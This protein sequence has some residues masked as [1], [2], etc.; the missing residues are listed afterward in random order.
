MASLEQSAFEPSSQLKSEAKQTDT[1]TELECEFSGCSWKSPK[2]EL[3]TVV[4]LMKMHFAAKHAKPDKVAKVTSVKAEKAKRPEIAIEMTD[5]DWAYF[6]S[7]WSAYKKATGLEGEDIMLQ[8]MECC[9]EQLRKD[10]YRNFPSTTS[11]SSESILLAQLKQIA[12][13]VK[14]RAVNRFKL[15]TLHQDKG[16][17]IRRF[18][19]RCRGLAS[20]SEYSVQFTA[21][22]VPVNYTDEV[23]IDQLITGIAESKIQKDVLSHTEAKKFPLGEA[24]HIC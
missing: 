9:C 22:H 4:E 12:V 16:E 6:L 10:H 8:L 5:E 13:R 2:G 17:P 23:I 21:C 18:A 7:R 14:N 19:G 15:S 24:P 11:S 20:V 1:M 3:T